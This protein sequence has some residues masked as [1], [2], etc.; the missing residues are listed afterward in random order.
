[1][2]TTFEVVPTVRMLVSNANLVRVYK[3]TDTAIVAKQNVVC[4]QL[5]FARTGII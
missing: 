3:T 4:G 1:M 2:S 5:G